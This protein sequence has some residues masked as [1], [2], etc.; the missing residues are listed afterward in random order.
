MRRGAMA[1]MIVACVG[2]FSMADGAHGATWTVPSAETPTLEFALEPGATPVR[3]GD[4]IVLTDAATYQSTYTVSI[5]N[6]TIRAAAGQSITIDAQGAGRVFTVNSG[7]SGL[8]LEGLTITGGNAIPDGGGI[9]AIEAALTVRGC[10]VIGN[11]ADDD[12]GGISVVLADVVIEDSVIADNVLLD[13]Q[14]NDDGG[15]LVVRSGTLTMS[16]STLT[17]NST[18]G[19]GGGAL[20]DGVVVDISGCLIEGNSAK[21]GGGL[22]FVGGS[23]GLVRDTR[24]AGNTANGDGG[25]SNHVDSDVDYLRCEFVGNQTAGSG[26]DDGGALSLAGAYTTPVELTSC[27]LANNVA[28]SQGGAASV[29]STTDDLTRARFVN[30]TI[31][32]NTAL[33]QGIGAGGGAMRLG[34]GDLAD[35][36]GSIVRSNT[37]DQLIGDGYTV[38]YSNVEGGFAGEMVI[39]ADPLFVDEA[40]GDYRLAAGSPCADAGDTPA[41]VGEAPTDLAGEPRAADDPDAPDVGMPV[42]GMVVDMGAYERPAPPC[43]GGTPGVCPGDLDGDDDVDVFD[44]AELAAGFGCT[45]D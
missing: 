38:R 37:P 32:G 28:R 30:C 31:V 39:D 23:T 36:V 13:G 7:G 12:G 11:V 3:D 19:L 34:T 21:H 20:L 4:V 2:G 5:P 16:G 8:T 26:A 40:A 22:A 10:V 18:G 45:P 35:I 25:G 43:S 24:L 17:G 41:V 1:A 42:F 6:L 33:G 27:L 9:E 15:G 29:T 14:S 44:F